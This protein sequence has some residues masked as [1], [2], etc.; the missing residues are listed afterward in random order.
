MRV[1]Q[2]R[3]V[4]DPGVWFVTQTFRTLV[5]VEYV[6]KSDFQGALLALGIHRGNFDHLLEQQI[7]CYFQVPASESLAAAYALHNSDIAFF[8]F[9]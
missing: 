6:G 9:G 7:Q 1:G 3:Q 8:F 4:D 2:E 5:G